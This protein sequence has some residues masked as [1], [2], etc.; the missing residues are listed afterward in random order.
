MRIYSGKSKWQQEAD[1]FL[2]DSRHGNQI[3]GSDY[4]RIRP[5]AAD[6]GDS[7]KDNS[8]TEFRQQRINGRGQI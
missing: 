2:L 7:E 6:P 8:P 3:K 5:N 1:V 4:P